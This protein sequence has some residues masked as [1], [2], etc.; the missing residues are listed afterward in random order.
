MSK[1]V[2]DKL[3]RDNIPNILQDKGKD[4]KFHIA[5]EDE[6]GTKLYEKL[7]EEVSELLSYPCV[8]ELADVYEVLAEIADR[9]GYTPQDI[10]DARIKKNHARGAFKMKYI[11]ESVSEL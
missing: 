9:L 6:Y 8:D 10:A 5:D 11:L 7:Q 3:V 2:Y 1:I 4:F